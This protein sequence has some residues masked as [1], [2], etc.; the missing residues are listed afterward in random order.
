MACSHLP[1]WVRLGAQTQSRSCWLRISSLGPSWFFCTLHMPAKTVCSPRCTQTSGTPGKLSVQLGI[2]HHSKQEI[3]WTLNKTC[4]WIRRLSPL[5]PRTLSTDS[6]QV[7]TSPRGS[8][9]KQHNLPLKRASRSITSPVIYE[10][11]IQLQ[12][13]IIISH[14]DIQFNTPESKVPSTVRDTIQSVTYSEWKPSWYFPHGCSKLLIAENGKGPIIKYAVT[15]FIAISSSSTQG[16]RD[17]ILP[18]WRWG[19]DCLEMRDSSDWTN[20]ND[21]HS[22]WMEYMEICM[23]SVVAA[24]RAS[25]HV[26]RTSRKKE[27]GCDL[28]W[29]HLLTTAV[30]VTA[31]Y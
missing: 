20:L 5:H 31:I 26:C 16:D 13:H 9:G 6:L 30:A 21:P 3:V 23:Q 12:I 4:H 10:L 18:D 22:T 29:P 15:H 8:L 1:V 24:D 25:F 27:L 11:H 7:S 2:T 28:S 14:D 17:K 19:C